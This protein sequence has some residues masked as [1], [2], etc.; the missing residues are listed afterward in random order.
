MGKRTLPLQCEM[1]DLMHAIGSSFGGLSR[2]ED[3]G[4]YCRIRV[5]MNVQKPIKRVIFINTSIMKYRWVPFKYQNLPFF[6]TLGV[7]V[8]GIM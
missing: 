4:E 8:L 1:K 6:F 5:Q 3:K 2:G 7:V